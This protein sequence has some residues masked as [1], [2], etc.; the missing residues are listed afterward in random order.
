[1]EKVAASFEYLVNVLRHEAYVD[2]LNDLPTRS[3]L[4]PITVYLAR[5][6]TSFRS[7]AQ[8]AR[9]IRWMFLAG[10]WARYSG[11][12]ESTLQK[13]VSLLD[14]PDP[15]IALE[16]AILRRARA[17]GHSNPATYLARVRRRPWV[18]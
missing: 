11:S 16:E 6:G 13:D 8:Q 10:I 18:K 15:T 17:A 2:S 12:T 14:A 9:F 7:A 5:T 4:L 3:V 1:M